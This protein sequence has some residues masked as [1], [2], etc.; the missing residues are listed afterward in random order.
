MKKT[1]NG[2]ERIVVLFAVFGGIA[3][4]YFAI[5][6]IT[7]PKEPSLESSWM[8]QSEGKINTIHLLAYML[9]RNEIDEKI[10]KE[11]KRRESIC[12]NTKI[13]LI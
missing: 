5:N 6:S 4:G 10:A 1:L 12:L 2:W 3:S 8:I 13:D 7:F 9:R 11:M